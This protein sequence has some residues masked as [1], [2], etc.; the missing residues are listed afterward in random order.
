MAK[1]SLSYDSNSV[2]FRVT[3]L[4]SGQYVELYLRLEDGNSAIVDQSYT[5][6]GSTLTR[7]FDVLSP[8]KE[9]AAN[10]KVGSSGSDASWIGKQS[11]TAP[12]EETV[13]VE[14]WSW[15]SSNGLASASQT[16]RAY[17]A[18]SSGGNISEFSHLVWNDMV[19]K[20]KE[21]L[22]A[23]GD[24]WYSGYETY[25]ATRMSYSD[26][27]LTASRFNALRDNIG[28]HIA[29]GISPVSR[30]DIVYGWYFTRLADRINQWINK[31]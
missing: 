31:L 27:E 20:V 16:A 25:S 9:Y 18:V 28:Q 22:D 17:D 23:T 3:G 15:Y 12:E 8:G 11:F 4:T 2:T 1:Y 6:A 5:A 14:L 19:D 24:T 13:S 29:T 21:I 7:T 10:V 30:G 26:K